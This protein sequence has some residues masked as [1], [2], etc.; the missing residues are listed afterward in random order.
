VFEE[1]GTEFDESQVL[2]IRDLLFA[3]DSTH[4]RME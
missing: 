4:R 3:I 2:V 1:A